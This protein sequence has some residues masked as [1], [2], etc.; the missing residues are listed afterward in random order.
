MS[1][2]YIFISIWS[3]RFQSQILSGNGSILYRKHA[4][5]FFYIIL[6]IGVCA[7]NNFITTGGADSLHVFTI[8]NTFGFEQTSWGAPIL[9]YQQF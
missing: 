5:F 6:A 4:S 1:K 8:S 2:T 9:I 7:G 3:N